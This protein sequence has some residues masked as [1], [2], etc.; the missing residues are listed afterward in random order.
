MKTVFITLIGLSIL[1]FILLQSANAQ[2]QNT[3]QFQ[4]TS[5]SIYLDENN[6]IKELTNTTETVQTLDEAIAITNAGLTGTGGK[7]MGKT[8]IVVNNSTQLVDNSVANVILE[9]ILRDKV[10][11]SENPPPIVRMHGIWVYLGGGDSYHIQ[12]AIE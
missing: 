2:S 8:M 3:T 6:T 7:T 10:E 12:G 4:M 11:N 5:V 1:P 9:K